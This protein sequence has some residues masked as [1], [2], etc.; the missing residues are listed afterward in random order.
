M[1][2][3]ELKFYAKFLPACVVIIGITWVGVVKANRYFGQKNCTAFATLS[4]R[5]TKFVE[6]SYG[7]FDCLTPAKDGKWIS[8][9][10]LRE[11]AD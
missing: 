2:R 1:D 7:S 4:G 5:E 8:A 6:Y 11:I 3:E 9:S 10:A